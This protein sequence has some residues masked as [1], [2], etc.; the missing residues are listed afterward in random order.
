MITLD[1]SQL[2]HWVSQFYWPL[3]R[4]LA[5]FATAPFSVNVPLVIGSKLVWP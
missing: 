1:S 4:L 5:L 2:V 3:V